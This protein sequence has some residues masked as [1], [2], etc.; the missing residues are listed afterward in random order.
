[1]TRTHGLEMEVFFFVL[2]QERNWI[3]VSR[4]PPAAPQLMHIL[5]IINVDKRQNNSD[6]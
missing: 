3:S 4:P 6:H 1:M 5:I 2:V